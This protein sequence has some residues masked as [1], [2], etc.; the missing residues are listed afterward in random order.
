L[1][2]TAPPLPDI[3][4]EVARIRAAVPD[5]IL[6][7]EEQP[8]R[9]MFWINVR[10]RSIAAVAKVLRDDKTLDYKMFCDLFGVDR[11]EDEKR[12]NVL[13]NL[14]SVSRNRRIFLRVR[15]ADG[16]AVPTLSGV[17][18]GA[19][20][21]EREIYDLLG[22]HFEGHPNLTRI[23][24]PEE[25]EGHPLR[26]DYPAVGKRPVLLYNDVKDVL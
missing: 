21:P 19:N 18:P 7:V 5:A 12:L 24:L 10:P 8:E 16:E 6:S 2:A 11:P 26:K 15:V 4:A 9:G 1:A 3:K 25:W 23:L 13:Y 22:V 14:Y 17:Y 20:W